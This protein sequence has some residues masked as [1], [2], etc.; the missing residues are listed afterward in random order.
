MLHCCTLASPCS[1]SSCTIKKRS[2]S[3]ESPGSLVDFLLIIERVPKAFTSTQAVLKVQFGLKY[4][5]ASLRGQHSAAVPVPT[6]DVENRLASN[7]KEL[8]DAN[9]TINNFRGELKTGRNH[10]VYNRPQVSYQYFW[11]VNDCLKAES[12][13]RREVLTWKMRARDL[14]LRLSVELISRHRPARKKTNSPIA[15]LMSI[16]G[17]RDWLMRDLALSRP[18]IVSAQL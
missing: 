11:V 14:E 17:A 6:F 13:C 2:W 16:L 18:W 10:M 3:S 5:T 8:E 12:N 15:L 7:C 1:N 4:E 9:D